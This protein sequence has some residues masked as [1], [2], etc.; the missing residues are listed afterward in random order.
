MVTVDPGAIILYSLEAPL[1][2][3]LGS[4]SSCWRY[5]EVTCQLGPGGAAAAAAAYSQ[6][7][8][9]CCYCPYRYKNRYSHYQLAYRIGV[10]QIISV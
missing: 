3:W 9:F 5:S 2:S 4:S 6:S 1:P 7:Q 10:N 8:E